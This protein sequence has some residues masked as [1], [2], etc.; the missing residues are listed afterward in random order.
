MTGM[1]VKCGL[2]IRKRNRLMDMLH[3]LSLSEIL[4]RLA[5]EN[6]VCWYGRVLRRR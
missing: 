6:I 5:M 4:D 2:Q 3:I 1:R